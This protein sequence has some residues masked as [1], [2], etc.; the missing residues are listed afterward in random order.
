MTGH[1]RSLPDKE[2]LLRRVRPHRDGWRLSAKPRHMEPVGPGEESVWDFPRPPA[3]EPVAEPIKVVHRGHTVAATTNGLRVLET[4]GA[5][6]YHI[7]IADV[8]M[9]CLVENGH[10]TVCEWKGAAVY[11][12][13]VVDGHT[14]QDAA[15]TY[16]DPFDD[17]G[18][19]FDALADTIVFYASRV[20]EAYV[21]E[22]KVSPQPGGY[23]SGWVTSR[24]KGPIK[25]GPGTEGW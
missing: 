25:G 17:L 8:D 2:T 16:P 14:V 3:V 6:V 24:L 10:L 15:Y 20:D 19:G 11:Y 21:G 5:P 4:A 22:E 7:P 23:Y 9:S 13:L 12:D 1:G 18:R